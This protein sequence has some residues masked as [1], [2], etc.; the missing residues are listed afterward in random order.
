MQELRQKQQLLELLHQ[1]AI[2]LT[3]NNRLSAALLDDYFNYCEQ[4]TITKPQCL[5]YRQFI[6]RTFEQYCYQHPNQPYPYL[7]NEMHCQHLWQQIIQM[8]ETITYSEGLLNTVLDTWK[9]CE[10]WLISP[11]DQAF[12]Y[13]QQTRQFQCWWQEFRQKLQQLE[14]IS[15][16]QLA[17]YL[18]HNDMFLIN[19]PLIWASFDEFTPQQLKLQEQC[20]THN[21]MQY[22]YDLEDNKAISTQLLAADNI[23]EEQQQLVFWIQEQLHTNRFIAEDKLQGA[24]K[25]PKIGIVVPELQQS[26]TMLQ[27]M[28]AEHI[29]PAL[30]NIS[31]GQKLSEFPIIAHALSWLHLT[32]SK[33]T[34][35]QITL[36][37]QSPYIGHAQEELLQRAHC[38]QNCQLLQKRH[39][40][41]A[42]LIE[43]LAQH[44]PLLAQSLTKLTAYPKLATP[45]EWVQIFQDRLNQLGY[46]GTLGL[47]SEQ[48]QCHARL[49]TLFDEFRELAFIH[50]Q[51]S[52]QEALDTF[53][54]LTSNTVFQP[55]KKPAPIQILGLLEASG[56]EFDYLWIMGLTDQCLPGKTKRAPLIPPSLQQSLKMPHSHPDREL[57]FAQSTLQRLRLGA[58]YS[59]F[60]YSKLQGDNP[61]LPC[62]LITQFP[63]YPKRTKPLAT[64]Q[65][66]LWDKYLESYEVP[67][68]PEEH[69]SGGTTLLSNQAQCPFKSFA[70]HRLQ[71]KP[72]PQLSEEFDS[73]ERG[74][75]IHKVMEL[76]WK[77]L[78]S[79]S[80]LIRLEEQELQRLINQCISDTLHLGQKEQTLLH[81][82]E[83][84]RLKRLVHHCLEWE[85][86]RPPFTILALEHSYT[87]TLSGLE[88]QMR[89]DR[90][91]EVD[92]AQWVID[93]KSSIP[94][95]K[96]WNE[97]RPQQPQLLLYALLNE[98]INTL[99]FL[100]IKTGAIL[101]SGLSEFPSDVK[102]IN[103]LKK[104]ECWS[105]IREHWQEQ[106]N[107]LAQEVIHGHCPPQPINSSICAYCDFKNLCRI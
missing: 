103:R 95:S 25:P 79:Q 31:L 52:T 49:N 5:P 13:T 48:Y 38:Q 10:Q 47:S 26:S 32:T 100:Q 35:Q 11:E 24:M 21:I 29:D 57:Y 42:E 77:K 72:L 59:V 23:Q 39:C 105:Q 74:Q 7:I 2:V 33:Y 65:S 101:C 107:E 96:P 82:I 84:E 75:I 80:N 104:D 60:S 89:V 71:A 16:Y 102:G 45:Q 27:R 98:Q 54:Q 92:D 9:Q 73:K 64:Q 91:D 61:T 99:L 62:T 17:P 78:N 51:L 66:E 58:K 4:K 94:N 68:L 87:M 18:L 67:L 50:H 6:T 8:E 28:L 106:L 81:Q 30:F 55:Q 63:E 69:I 20:N 44:T 88:I 14:A 12:C 46:P 97:D 36:L 34:H 19:T 85:K 41:Y 56:C 53:T 76:L 40:T 90:L 1:G 3:P 15:E 93:Y 83:H 22:R 43:Q 37:L 86:K 70:T